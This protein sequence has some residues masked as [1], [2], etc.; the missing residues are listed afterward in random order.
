MN[1]LI[2]RYYKSEFGL[3]SFK[4]TMHVLCD[5]VSEKREQVRLNES[6]HMQ[7][8]L[9]EWHCNELNTENRDT[10]SHWGFTSVNTIV[11]PN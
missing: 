11:N 1:Y 9:Q 3:S 10:F 2:I 8:Q 6:P 7:T 5:Y 4:S